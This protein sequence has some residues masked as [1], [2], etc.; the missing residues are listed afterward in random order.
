MGLTSCCAWLDLRRG[1]LAIGIVHVTVN[2]LCVMLSVVFLALGPELLLRPL[3]LSKI[4]FRT[5]VALLFA[6]RILL[7][8]SLIVSVLMLI[9]SALLIR[10]VLIASE[11]MVLTWLVAHGL[12]LVLGSIGY[13]YQLITAIGSGVAV[14]IVLA[15]LAIVWAVVQW[16]WYTVVLFFYRT[17][18]AQDVVE[19]VQP[20]G[21]SRVQPLVSSVSGSL[22]A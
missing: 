20:T 17:I 10:G 19:K 12:V 9:V 6:L 21:A 22:E 4:D 3:V 14:P 16:Y 18:G 7:W 13:V 15:L 1:S 8:V 2:A 5:I 11:C